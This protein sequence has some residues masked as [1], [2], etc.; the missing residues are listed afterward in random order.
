MQCL[1][2]SSEKLENGFRVLR[3]H[4]TERRMGIRKLFSRV[5]VLCYNY[6]G[7]DLL[8]SEFA[9]AFQAGFVSAT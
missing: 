4:H 9:R 2:K 8:E 5:V 3:G 7:L 1:W 6:V